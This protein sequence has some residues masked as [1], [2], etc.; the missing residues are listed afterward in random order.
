MSE[1]VKKRFE[2]SQSKQNMINT[3]ASITTLVV[4]TL[5]SM[6]LSPYIVR[7]IGV[8]ANG[9]IGLANNFISYAMLAQTALNSMGS[10]FLMIAYYNE[11]YDKARKYYSSIFFG[12][13]FL[14]I[15]FAVIGGI[16]VWRLENILKITSE[17]LLDVKFL[18]ALLFGNYVINTLITSWSSAPYIKNKL[19]VQS[20]ISILTTLARAFVI[21]LMFLALAP[22]VWY[23][24]LGSFVAGIIGV[25]CY[26]FAKRKILPEF[27][28]SKRDFS[29]AYIKEL[30][31]SGVW[32]SISSL[33]TILLSGLDLLLA[34]LF[35]GPTA[36]GLLSLA[37]TMPNFVDTL[38]A[39]IADVFT[40]SLIIDYSHKNQQ[41]MISTINQSSKLIAIICSLPLAFLLIFGGRFY[42]LWQPTENA[43]L[44]HVLSIVTIFGRCFFTGM[45][46][47]FKIFMVVN[48]VKEN[49]II[50]IITGAVS[51]L[52]TFILLKTTNLGL[53]AIAGTSV[54][55]CF[56]KNI[57]YVI[58]Y[59]A[60]YLGVKKATF[61]QTLVPSVLCCVLLS[62]LGIGLTFIFVCNTWGNLILCASVF[63]FMGLILTLFVVLRKNERKAF[64][65][66]LLKR[67]KH[68]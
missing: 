59:S 14:G 64:I 36:M 16:C 10:R 13:L 26:Y 8:E 5:I 35:L 7:T 45:Q 3:M 15:I 37:K 22:S 56:V 28:V 54:V 11:D 20:L 19:Y 57:V 49:S 62:V 6:I 17:L 23:V 30:I 12:N 4:T 43:Q 47:L 55:C 44:L 24:G 18:F 42:S 66:I 65:R 60:K 68:N 9:F 39:T 63:A 40:P 25:L 53:F 48:K 33:G 34:N 38:N 67:R 51:T 46:P 21:L 27:K 52:I 1:K 61:Y 41:Q 58:P 31:A 50:T 29:W 2:L 32:N